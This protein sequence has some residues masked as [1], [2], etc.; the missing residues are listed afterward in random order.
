MSGGVAARSDAQIA[1]LAD[2]GYVLVWTDSGRTHNTNGSAIV[3][4]RYD[5]LGN[6][7]GGEVK[8]SQFS[9]GDQ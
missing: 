7:V 3:E 2:G 8:I 6:T 1:R 9:S 5:S 4:Q